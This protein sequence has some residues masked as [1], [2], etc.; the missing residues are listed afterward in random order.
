MLYNIL[1]NTL[2]NQTAARFL[3]FGYNLGRLWAGE[4]YTLNPEN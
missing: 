2:L 1:V 3:Q 4:A